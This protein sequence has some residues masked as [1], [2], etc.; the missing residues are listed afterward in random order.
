[1]KI[2]RFW[3]NIFLPFIWMAVTGS[4][5]LA[6]FAVGFG[7]SSLCLW[8]LS[9]PSDAPLVVV[10]LQRVFRFM[11]FFGFFVWEL[12]LANLRV[13]WEVITPAHH[14]QPAIIAVPLDTETDLQTTVLANFITLTP[15]TLSLDVSPDGGTLFVHAMYVDDPDT[16]R[17]EIKQR[18]ERRVMEVFK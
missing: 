13:A 1:M 5:T 7:L 10:T 12:L 6:N 14:M 15:G 2:N 11:Q 18:L 17:R 4:F 3:G 16:F 8:L 9:P